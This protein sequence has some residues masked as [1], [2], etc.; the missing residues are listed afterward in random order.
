[1]LPELTDWA[2]E[3]GRVI[4]IGDAAHAMSPASGQGGSIAFEDAETL[5]YALAHDRDASGGFSARLLSLWA[6]HR[7]QRVREVVAYAT[8]TEQR[9]IPSPNAVLQRIKEWAVWGMLWYHGEAGMSPWVSTYDGVEQM[10]LL[11]N[12]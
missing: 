4:I 7:K 11:C 1:V 3:S 6:A 10:A 8:E 9:R 5:A 12:A 2:S